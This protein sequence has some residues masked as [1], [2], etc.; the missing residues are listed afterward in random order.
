M[1]RAEG[2]GF[3]GT[4][5][6]ELTEQAYVSAM[7]FRSWNKN[8]VFPQDVG[9][10]RILDIGSGG[11]N[12]SLLLREKGAIVVA[13]DPRHK[14]LP[15]LKRFVDKYISDRFSDSEITVDQNTQSGELWIAKYE[16]GVNKRRTIKA[17]DEFL[18]QA[19]AGE[20]NVAG[21]AEAL[22]FLDNSFDFIFSHD[23][24]SRIHVHNFEMFIQA[25]QEGL[26]V[27]K[28]GKEFQIGPW[29]AYG[30]AVSA[31]IDTVQALRQYLNKRHIKYQFQPLSR[32]EDSLRLHIIKPERNK[33]SIFNL[34]RK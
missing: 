27:L 9:G 15:S 6:K 26:R 10:L 2:G 7:D 32:T 24:I 14:D 31:E 1:T 29:A 28:P 11:S 4:T 3:I 13:L 5:P 25:I 18:N 22:P 33:R 19:N 17:F 30:P 34:F 12:S 8:I 16:L 21:T 20:G 23:C